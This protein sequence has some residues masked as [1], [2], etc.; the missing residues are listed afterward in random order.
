MGRKEENMPT[1]ESLKR[2]QRAYTA[3][4]GGVYTPKK[5]DPEKELR[6]LREEVRLLRADKTRL[7]R[8]LDKAEDLRDSVF[9]LA[10]DDFG[11]PRW[12][13]PK[14]GRKADRLHKPILFTSDFQYGEVVNPAE[15]DGMNAF[16]KRIFAER[17][18]RMID[19]TIKWADAIANG[20]GALYNQGC[21]YLRG[22]DAI[23]GEIHDELRETNDASVRGALQELAAIER[24]GIRR[25]RDRFG[26]VHVISIPGNH[27]RVTMKPRHKRYVD[28]NFETILADLIQ[29]KFE[30]EPGY[31]FETPDSGYAYFNAAGWEFAL[32]HGDRMGAGG[33][34]GYIGAPAPITKG[35]LRTR[36]AAATTG[37]MVD[38]VLTGHLHTSMKLPRGFA[39][40]S[41]PG[42]NEFARSLNLDPDAA[43]QWLIFASP[44]HV[45]GVE[46]E[47]SDFPKRGLI[48]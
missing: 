44:R 13:A 19:K 40:G 18:A 48:Q 1:E 34:T 41:M 4:Q 10:L 39:N 11:P 23:S 26:H 25:L 21:V 9:H 8:D 17:Y 38:F 3:Q 31:T 15:M 46:L 22:G 20:W 7:Q 27:G 6:R 43:K 14:P 5:E 47:L 33:G 16:N 32:L 28:L 36:L 29:A 37:R 42:Y 24:E 45:Y 30:R 2:Y 35:H 12:P